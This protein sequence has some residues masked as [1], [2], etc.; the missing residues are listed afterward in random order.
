MSDP[1]PA[2]RTDIDKNWGEPFW[3]WGSRARAE[4][5]NARSRGSKPTGAACAKW[6]TAEL[7]IA[8][9]GL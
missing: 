3:Q 7:A 5:C 6:S 4:A 9:D 1:P 2:S 8:E